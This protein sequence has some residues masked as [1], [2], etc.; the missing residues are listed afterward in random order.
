MSAPVEKDRNTQD[1]WMYAPR[2]AQEGEGDVPFVPSP[3]VTEGAEPENLEQLAAHLAATMTPPAPVA[4]PPAMP[5][6]GEPRPEEFAIVPPWMQKKRALEPVTMPLPPIETASRSRLGYAVRA[7]ALASVAAGGAYLAV[8][9][10]PEAVLQMMD[11][12]FTDVGAEQPAAAKSAKLVAVPRIVPTDVRGVA[13]DW[14]ALNIATEAAPSGGDAVL[15]G[16]PAGTTLSAGQDFGPA[17]WR[18]EL[19]DLAKLRAHVPPGYSGTSDL[20]V[21]L[22]RS[23]AV[24]LDRKAMRFDVV[25]PR[26][27]L[28]SAGPVHALPQS[29]AKDNARPIAPA[30]AAPPRQPDNVALAALPPRTAPAPQ[31]EAVVEAP[32][33]KLDPAELAVMLRRGEELARTGDLAG[34]RLLLQR[35]ADARHPGAAFALAATFDPVVLKQIAVIGQSGDADK[36]RLW[37][38][39]ARELGSKEAALRLEA[40]ARWGK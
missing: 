2:W 15:S 40:L 6:M 33:R 9:G 17:G 31:K 22:R 36:A 32:A 7:L 1:G 19:A 28:A 21:E 3:R 35:A 16:L 18:I 25:S 4:P 38:E 11:A 5:R 34:A 24:V 30:P 29:E 20:V 39:R 8:Y 37:Y 27:A 10:P 26:L 14:I 23:D 12:R 13:G